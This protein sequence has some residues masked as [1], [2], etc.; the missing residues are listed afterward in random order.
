MPPPLLLDELWRA[1]AAAVAAAKPLLVYQI[2]VSVFVACALVNAL[3]NA[4]AFG[5]PRPVAPA[6][7]A[8]EDGALCWPA[9]SVLIPARNEAATLR[10]C[11]GSLLDQEYPGPLEILVLDD[12]SEDGTGAVAAELAAGDAR[13]RVLTGG[14]LLPGWKGKPNALRQ[15]AGAA[16][17]ELLLLTD[18][19]CVFFPGGLTAAVRHRETSGADCL[20]LLP[21][22]E[23]RSFWEHVVVP[24]QIFLVFVTLPIRNV[25]ASRNPAFAAANGA[26]LLLPSAAYAALGG[27]QAVKGEMA[28]DIK[29]AQH[30]KRQGKRL[31]YGDGS[32]V[33][34]VR[35]YES[36]RGIWDGFSKNLFPAMGKSLPILGVWS[37]F[38]LTTQ[39]LPFGFVLGALATGDASL[40]FF[41]L[42]LAH[43]LI[44]L[45]IRIALSLRFGQSLWA[46]ATHPLGW[47]ITLAIGV[48]SAYL[49]LSGRGHSWKG[50]V[51]ET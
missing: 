43:V 23:C 7:A 20:S 32:R 5:R 9:L 22:L 40:P 3:S 8:C 44:A 15:L 29:F 35:M 14:P 33:Y 46:A 24:L 39:V 19:D 37:L 17:G 41:W 34:S 27:H 21:H 47:L 49:A 13:V 42:P 26:F 4:R 30:V 36:L 2:V 16:S 31:V 28:E 48:N 1:A 6:A 25:T 50:R 45:A 38:L 18:A 12:H 10:P 11:V 51:Y